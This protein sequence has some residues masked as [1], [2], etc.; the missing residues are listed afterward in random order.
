MAKTKL[1]RRNA[2]RIQRLRDECTRILN[3][4][5]PDE[6]VTEDERRRAARKLGR[7]RYMPEKK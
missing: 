2:V 6:A 7:T 3:T 5:W 1:P 4:P